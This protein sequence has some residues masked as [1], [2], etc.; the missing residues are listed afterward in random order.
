MRADMIHYPTKLKPGI[1]IAI[2]NAI[3]DA[4]ER[5]RIYGNGEREQET[6]FVNE[7]GPVGEAIIL[8]GK[9]LPKRYYYAY[10]RS[11]FWKIKASAAK[12]YAGGRCQVCNSKEDLNA[13]HRTYERLGREEYIDITVLCRSCHSLFHEHRNLMIPDIKNET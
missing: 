12:L 3:R 7:L 11:E 10:I 5:I 6:E 9:V 1:S 4:E 8:G 13:H 2:R